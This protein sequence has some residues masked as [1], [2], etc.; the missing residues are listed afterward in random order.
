M[1]ELSRMMV[2]VLFVLTVAVAVLLVASFAQLC[3]RRGINPAL[4]YLLALFTHGALAVAFLH[5][6]ARESIVGLW[7][8]VQ[9]LM[10]VACVAVMTVPSWRRCTARVTFLTFIKSAAAQH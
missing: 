6:A 10:L 9:G 8:G 7:W 3:E 1:D 2:C 4:C 5:C